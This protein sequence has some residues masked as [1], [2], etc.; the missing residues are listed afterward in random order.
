MRLVDTLAFPV[1]ARLLAWC[2]QVCAEPVCACTCMCVGLRE[3]LAPLCVCGSVCAGSRYGGLPRFQRRDWRAC[4]PAGVL[5]V[6]GHARCWRWRHRSTHKHKHKH[7]HGHGQ[8][9]VTV[10]LA[11]VR[12]GPLRRGLTTAPAPTCVLTPSWSCESGI[13]PGSHAIVTRNQLLSAGC[14]DQRY[15]KTSNVLE[16]QTVLPDETRC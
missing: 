9:S 14:S 15:D 3:V 7:K 8:G 5:A 12:P 6:Q 16:C 2:P 11:S 4:G 10:K 1:C 13:A